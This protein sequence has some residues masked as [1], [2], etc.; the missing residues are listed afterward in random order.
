MYFSGVQKI[1]TNLSGYMQPEL[2]DIFPGLH[3]GM[4]GDVLRD[5]V[6]EAAFP[7]SGI[8]QRKD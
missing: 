6:V 3:A 2:V 8:Y 4:P 7:Q 5:V 1:Q